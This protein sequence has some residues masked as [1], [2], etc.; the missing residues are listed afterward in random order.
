MEEI[1]PERTQ[2]LEKIILYLHVLI[3]MIGII[4]ARIEQSTKKM[5][6]SLPKSKE[7]IVVQ[8]E[9]EEPTIGNSHEVDKL[10]EEGTQHELEVLNQEG[11]WDNSNNNAP[12]TT[13]FEEEPYSPS[14]VSGDSTAPEKRHIMTPIKHGKRN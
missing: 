13:T 8:E 14:H 4:G 3:I 2:K 12:T 9:L 5:K 10:L 6:G 11:C 7:S 1:K